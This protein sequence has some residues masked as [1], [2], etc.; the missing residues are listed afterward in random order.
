MTTLFFA[1]GF[2]MGKVFWPAAPFLVFLAVFIT[3]T[4]SAFLTFCNIWIL[5]RWAFLDLIKIWFCAGLL[6]AV[7]TFILTTTFWVAF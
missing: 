2:H 6:Q 5:I 4:I 7:S 3:S 1:M